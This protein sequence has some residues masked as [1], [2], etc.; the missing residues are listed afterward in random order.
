V[1]LQTHLDVILDDEYSIR[2]R[3]LV[4]GEVRGHLPTGIRREFASELDP[5]DRRPGVER[6]AQHD[7]LL[8]PA[9]LAHDL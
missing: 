8:G 1:L 5:L 7:D 4:R 6:F 9:A 3:P 2:S